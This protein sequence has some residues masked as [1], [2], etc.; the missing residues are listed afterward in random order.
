M[1]EWMDGKVGRWAGDGRTGY[2][3][4][5]HVHPHTHRGRKLKLMS[6]CLLFHIDRDKDTRH[7]T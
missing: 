6:C 7:E 4:A 5:L 3:Q 2:D 1:D